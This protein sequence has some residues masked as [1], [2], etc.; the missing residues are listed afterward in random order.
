MMIFKSAFLFPFPPLSPNYFLYS[1]SN[2]HGL[3]FKQNIKNN[4]G[5]FYPFLNHFPD[6][7]D[8]IFPPQFLSLVSIL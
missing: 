8:W 4:I 2:I 6:D 1:E 3:K 7:V 5:Q